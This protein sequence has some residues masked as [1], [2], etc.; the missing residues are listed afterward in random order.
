MEH[1]TRDL[2]DLL[3]RH[4]GH[5]QFK[6]QQEEIITSV[7]NK[8]D[9]LVVMPTGG[10]KSLCY[11]LPALRFDGLTLVVSPLIALMTDQVEGLK[12]KGVPAAFIN[13]S[14]KREEAMRVQ[15]LA[16]KGKIKL[17]YVAPERLAMSGFRR[18]LARLKVDLVAIDEAHCI[19]VWGHDFRPDYRRLGELR[20]NLSGVPFLA[21]TATA[22]EQVRQDIIKQL[23]LATPRQFTHSFNRA[24]LNYRV[25]PKHSARSDFSALKALIQ[26]QKS[27]STIIYR[28]KRKSVEDLAGQLR[29][30][31][32]DA[33][34]YHAGLDSDSRRDIQESFMSGQ[35]PVIVATIAFGMGI[36]KPNIRLLV[37][38]DLPMTL[39]GYYQETGR[40]G[41][42]SHIADCVL[43][44]SKNDRRTLDYFI[45]KMEDATQ[46]RS[47]RK[48]LSQVLDYCEL[49]TCRRKYIL[50]YFGESWKVSN[51]GCCDNCLRSGRQA[52]P[53]PAGRT[54][55][56]ALSDLTVLLRIRDV[57]AGR[58][59]LNWSTQ[60][61]VHKWEGV[62]VDTS[63]SPPTVTEL[64][65]D[66]VGL[67]GLIP[68]E[69]G[70]IS[71][72]RILDL[73]NNELRGQIPPALGH[74][75]KLEELHLTNNKLIGTIPPSLGNLIKLEELL[76][77]G[78][79]VSGA[80]PS[81]LGNLEKLK[82]LFLD[83]NELSGEIPRELGNLKNLEA[84]A[85]VDNNLSGSIP[86]ELGNLTNLEVLYIADNQL[87]GCVPDSI[88]KARDNDLDK[89]GLPC[90]GN[91]D[92]SVDNRDISGDCAILLEIRDV[93]AES[94]TLNWSK[95]V[96]MQEWEGIRL[97]NTTVPSR[98]KEIHLN[99][100]ELTGTLPPSI[101][102]LTHLTLLHLRDNKLGGNIPSELGR[103]EK[104][105]WLSLS[106]NQLTGAIPKEL[107]N[108]KS[109]ERL[110]LR[111]NKLCGQI[112][113]ELGMLR[114]LKW[115]YLSHN[116]LHGPIP[117][118]FGFLSSLEWLYLSHNKLSGSVPSELEGLSR[119]KALSL[120]RN[121][122]SGCLPR[123]LRYIKEHD[124]AALGLPLCGPPPS[125]NVGGSLGEDGSQR[126]GRLKRLIEMLQNWG[127]DD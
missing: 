33:L 105:E 29:R 74:L 3:R 79:Q 111:N 88:A 10:G 1:T 89:L 27:G 112:P 125:T 121:K 86:K 75:Q 15:E 7:L 31:G 2:Y 98:V 21:L 8:E 57:L 36:D 40:A 82:G 92:N 20:R 116:D 114:N 97:D 47:A 110:F 99:G 23:Q 80:I 61:P 35:V 32:L 13:S 43:F 4:F 71:E 124:L 127:P 28:T 24:N 120:S 78:N 53:I 38:Y 119:L 6:G 77:G 117:S 109:L 60:V 12:K 96:P 83:G 18:F 65:L 113:T 11:Q 126:S 72:L 50:R 39:E 81:A 45:R 87:L 73:M 17:L 25:L 100:K 42:D 14:L 58:Y 26:K 51:C 41:R 44:Y 22:T 102:S 68:D 55:S 84:L 123:K 48:K 118:T 91:L 101:A 63:T 9:A 94:S 70:R 69:L 19:S 49:K 64:V 95:S 76:L 115:L 93:L 5:E 107:G 52:R 67:S 106:E 90:C 108:L 59:S 66:G 104:L 46:R 16:E 122:L 85:L 30:A 54:Q 34:P 62:S 56:G 37:H 103:L